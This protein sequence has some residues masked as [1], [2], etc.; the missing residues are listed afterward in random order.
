MLDHYEMQA[1]SART[2]RQPLARTI[3]LSGRADDFQR[4]EIVRLSEEL[5]GISTARW[6]GRKTIV[7]Q[8]PLFAE[9][10]LMALASFAAGAII[11]YVAALRRRLKEALRE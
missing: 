6:A 1:I 4:S 3:L 8:L 5:P 11:A 10:L 9:V 2:Q 7:R